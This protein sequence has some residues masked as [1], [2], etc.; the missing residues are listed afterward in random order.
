MPHVVLQVQFGRHLPG[1]AES[2]VPSHSS[3]GRFFELSPQL[4]PW[5]WLA[6]P[7][8]GA[9]VVCGIGLFGTRAL[10][11]SPPVLVLRELG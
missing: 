9:A 10:V 7:L 5:V 3:C 6:G 8:I 4:H 2:S 1:H 11:G